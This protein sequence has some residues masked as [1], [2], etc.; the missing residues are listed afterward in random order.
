MQAVRAG[1]C[2]LYQE[3]EAYP[4]AL[5]SATLKYSKRLY[6]RPRHAFFPFPA[7][8]PLAPMQSVGAIAVGVC[9]EEFGRL[10]GVAPVLQAH[11]EQL[12][13]SSSWGGERPGSSTAA[14]MITDGS[15]SATHNDVREGRPQAATTPTAGSSSS[16]GSGCIAGCDRQ[17][18]HTKL[19]TP[20]YKQ[21]CKRTA[22]E[23]ASISRIR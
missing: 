3:G 10:V 21:V 22:V 14:P 19:V 16:G 17:R 13:R 12:V 6:P 23:L 9:A 8:A 11:W 15:S 5:F 7:R 18:L 1:Q 4:A 2:A 20:A